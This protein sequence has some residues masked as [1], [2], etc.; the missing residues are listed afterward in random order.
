MMR[1]RSGNGRSR[2]SWRDALE[3]LARVRVAG[4]EPM[5]VALGVTSRQVDYYGARFLERGLARRSTLRDGGG[6]I[7]AITPRGLSE[8]GYPISSRSSTSSEGGLAHGRGVSWVAAHCETRGREWAGPEQLRS[9]GWVVQI[10]A[11]SGPGPL[12]HM[13][14]LGVVMEENRRWAVE[15]ERTS[16]K[17]SRVR[18]ILEGYREAQLRGDL[19]A[20]LYV[21][22]HESISRQIG[23]VAEEVE[24]DYAIRTLGEL[25]DETVAVGAT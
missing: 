20:V 10:S 17:R 11:A 15:Y 23:E 5:A 14:D 7:L 2:G 22:G 9:E 16:K 1:G 24:L 21:C 12:T 3:W 19:D 18:R 6:A 4:V 8:A 25:I 13:P